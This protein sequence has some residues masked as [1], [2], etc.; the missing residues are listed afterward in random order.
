MIHLE[1]T[2]HN[3]WSEC[4]KNIKVFHRAVTKNKSVELQFMKTNDIISFIFNFTIRQDHAGLNTNLALLG[5]NVK[6]SFYDVRHWDYEKKEWQNY[7]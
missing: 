5:Y 1:F 2:L 4:W 6:L 3:P 7:D